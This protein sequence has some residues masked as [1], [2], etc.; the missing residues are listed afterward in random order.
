M[1]S[2]SNSPL[3]AGGMKPIIFETVTKKMLADTASQNTITIS[4]D[5]VSQAFTSR[6]P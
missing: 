3:G 5:E 6:N 2:Y 1:E 4:T